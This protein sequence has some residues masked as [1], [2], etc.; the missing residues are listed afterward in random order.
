MFV[1][2]PVSFMLADAQKDSNTVCAALYL[3]LIK[4]FQRGK[5]T[6]V[7]KRKNG[8]GQE[9]RLTFMLCMP[10][11]FQASEMRCVQEEIMQILL[12]TQEKKE[13]ARTRMCTHAHNIHILFS[14]PAAAACH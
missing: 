13:H 8:C 5:D 11:L 10:N 14:A 3:E 6:E 7:Q 1:L 9:T 12:F 2:I 4:V